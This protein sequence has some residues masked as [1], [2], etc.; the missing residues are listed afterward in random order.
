MRKAFF[1][2][3]WQFAE[4]HKINLGPLAPYV[5]GEMI[6]RKGKKLD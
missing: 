6:G 5:F 4:K 3:L 2:W 1:T